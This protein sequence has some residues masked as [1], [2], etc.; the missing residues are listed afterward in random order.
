MISVGDPRFTFLN[1]ASN[2]GDG[3]IAMATIPGR[4]VTTPAQ[5]IPND[6]NASGRS[7]GEN[8][9]HMLR[10][11]LERGVLISQAGP[12]V[13]QLERAFA[14]WAGAAHC[15]AVGSGTAA[16]HTAIA[17]VD[18]K[19]GDEIISSPITD[20]GGVM[21]I[22]Y[23][24]AVPVFADVDP[25]TCNMTPAAVE[26][27]ITSR[28]RAIIVTHLFG[29]P[30]D[31]DGMMALAAKHG[32]MV[33]E[34][35]AQAFGATYRG[36]QVGTIGH[37]GC[38]SLQQGKHITCGEGGLVVTHD[39]ALAR[40]MKLF[41]DKGWPFGEDNP[42]HE[43][44]GLNYRMTELQGAVALAQV[45]RLDEF[46]E[47]R[48][49][50]A[51]RLTSKLRHVE[52]LVCPTDGADSRHVHWRYALRVELPL[53]NKDLDRVSNALR[54]VGARTAPRYTQKLAFEYGFLKHRR[55]FG[56]SGFPFVGPQRDGTTEPVYDRA[57]FPGAVAGLERLL[58]IAMNEKFDAA[59]IDHIAGTIIEA[60]AVA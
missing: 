18:P 57:A 13:P 49:A 24:G 44:L 30:A 3:G 48:R 34:D 42:D 21:P 31:M 6:A 16:L 37:I 25:R 26:R 2:Y 15:V 1:A 53:T 41:H 11:V 9:L 20:M 38:F 32:L 4:E 12:V 40:F 33:I 51:D 35:A 17:A 50:M 14:H 22:L 47:H 10:E 29:N 59:I 39:P 19:P 7:F 56:G 23:Q 27:C 60:L 36:R 8:E 54:D 43:F 52:G 46:V 28:T 5:T 45:G 58:C 55:M